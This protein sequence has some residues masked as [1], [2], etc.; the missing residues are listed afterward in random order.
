[1]SEKTT[2]EYAGKMTNKVV[3]DYLSRLAE[4]FRYKEFEIQGLGKRIH[5]SLEKTVRFELKALSKENEG[6]IQLEISWKE[7][8]TPAEKLEIIPSITESNENKS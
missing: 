8:M 2:F 1:M 5:F 3:S 6:E 7:D 4:A